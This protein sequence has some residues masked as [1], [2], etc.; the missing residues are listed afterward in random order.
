[1]LF[2]DVVKRTLDLFLNPLTYPIQSRIDY[3]VLEME[4][5]DESSIY[6]LNSRM[7]ESLMIGPEWGVMENGPNNVSGYSQGDEIERPRPRGVGH[8]SRIVGHTTIREFESS[9][10]RKRVLRGYQGVRSISLLVPNTRVDGRGHGRVLQKRRVRNR[11]RS[12]VG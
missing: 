7:V 9:I 1:M 10:V 3:K 5:R 11:N 12:R 4:T 2:P 6:I 8:K